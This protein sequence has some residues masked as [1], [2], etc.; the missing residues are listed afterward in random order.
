V[1]KIGLIGFWTTRAEMQQIITRDME[2][3]STFRVQVVIESVSSSGNKPHAPARDE[4]A[5]RDS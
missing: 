2:K 5:G 4:I 3:V 1:N